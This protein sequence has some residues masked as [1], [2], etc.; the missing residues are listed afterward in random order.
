MDTIRRNKVVKLIKQSFIWLNGRIVFCF[1]ITVNYAFGI[2]GGWADSTCS[3]TLVFKE[4]EDKSIELNSFNFQV[5]KAVEYTT[6]FTPNFTGCQKARKSRRFLFHFS[7]FAISI[8]FDN[9]A[10]FLTSNVQRKGTFVS[11]H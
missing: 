6:F 1:S 3:S 2:N 8:S 7:S 10:F 5:F 11:L 4:F 9:V